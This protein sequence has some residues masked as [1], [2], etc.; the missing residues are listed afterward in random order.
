MKD[1]ET[2]NILLSISHFYHVLFLSSGLTPSIS[3][4]HFS[5]AVSIPFASRMIVRCKRMVDL[6]TSLT[7]EVRVVSGAGVAEYA[8]EA[9]AVHPRFVVPACKY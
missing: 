5:H 6:L 3:S 9:V 7:P 8:A 1:D 2:E 4:N